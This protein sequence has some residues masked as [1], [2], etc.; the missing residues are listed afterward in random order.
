MHCPHCAAELPEDARYCLRCGRNL[1]APWATCEILCAREERVL[2]TCRFW[3]RVLR[4]DG[5]FSAGS[6][7]TWVAEFPACGD[8]EAQ[9][10]HAALVRQL[11][12]AGWRHVGRGWRWYNDRFERWSEGS[13]FANSP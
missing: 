2:I 1:A 6:S 10:A 12:T 13:T 8:P 9:A 7:P 5:L 3:A 11:L 4:P